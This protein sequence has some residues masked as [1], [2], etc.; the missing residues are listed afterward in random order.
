MDTIEVTTIGGELVLQSSNEKVHKPKQI[1][2]GDKLV[3]K[4]KAPMLGGDHS[5]NNLLVTGLVELCKVKPVGIDA[6]KWLGE[7]LIANNPNTPSVQ[8]VNDE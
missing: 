8:L 3:E 2:T 1:L 7:W 6:V 4:M 5:L